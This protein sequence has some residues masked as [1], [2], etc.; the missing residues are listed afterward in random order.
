MT[1]SQTEVTQLLL[2]W[3]N[4]D[5]SALDK[6]VPV[7]YEELR[8]LARYYM[9]RERQGHTRLRGGRR[10]LPPGP[11]AQ[12]APERPDRVGRRGDHP[13]EARCGGGH[14][15]ALSKVGPLGSP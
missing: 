5:K 10:A 3:G 12:L 15:L 4:G 1:S 7:V 9:R 14:L 2:D 11:P 8:R 6:L 13:I